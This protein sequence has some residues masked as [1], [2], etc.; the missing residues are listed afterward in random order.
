MKKEPIVRM[1]LVFMIIIAVLFLAEACTA[2][3]S[4][5]QKKA[6]VKA[7]IDSVEAAAVLDTS[8]ETVPETSEEATE[9][10]YT[11]P[12]EVYEE[13]PM[14]EEDDMYEPSK[15]FIEEAE[16]ETESEM[17]EPTE[18][19]TEPEEHECGCFYE[20]YYTEDPGWPCYAHEC[21]DCGQVEYFEYAED[22]EEQ[23]EDLEEESD[24]F[25]E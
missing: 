22:T 11:E 25:D 9:E 5:D 4:V 23:E 19:A 18:E 15:E 17:E 21:V 13:E 20:E 6:A 8:F 3:D 16:E 14:H 12:T 7:Q 24:C 2:N 10:A 1:A